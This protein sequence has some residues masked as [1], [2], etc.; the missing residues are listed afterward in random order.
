[1]SDQSDDALIQNIR[2]ETRRNDAEA[3]RDIGADET[4]TCGSRH[5]DVRN[6]KPSCRKAIWEEAAR[7]LELMAED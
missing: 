3:I 4:C 7:T 1:M 2:S 5:R 6:H